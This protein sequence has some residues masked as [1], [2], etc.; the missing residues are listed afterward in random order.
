VHAVLVGA[1]PQLLEVTIEALDLGEEPDV[2]RI[3]IEDPHR[4]VRI[5]RGHEAVARVVDRLQMPG[6]DEAGH[7]GNREVSHDR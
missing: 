7:A 4:I 3:A 2:E 5:H 6:R 1:A